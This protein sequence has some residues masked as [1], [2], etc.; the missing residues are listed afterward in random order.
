MKYFLTTA[1]SEGII[2]V[3]SLDFAQVKLGGEGQAKKVKVGE[4]EEPE[5]ETVVDV[6]TDGF[7]VM[8]GEYD[9]NRRITCLTTAE[10]EDSAAGVIKDG[11]GEEDEDE[12]EDEESDSDSDSEEDDEEEDGE[13]DEKED[14]E[15]GG[16]GEDESMTK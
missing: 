4:K 8:A 10:V 11:D 9:T 16:I 1:N 2:R 7:S 14:E 12:D 13:G 6:K 15:W 3:Y 5:K